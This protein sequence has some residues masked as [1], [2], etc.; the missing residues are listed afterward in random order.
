MADAGIKKVI[1][2]KENLPAFLGETQQYI[3]R[4]R[5]VSEDKNRISHW[6]TAYKLDKPDIDVIPYSFSAD[7]VAGT[8]TAIWTP[9]LDVPSFDVYVNF[10]D[11]GNWSF[12]STVSTNIYALLIPELSTAVQI[13]VQVPT[14][15]K[16]RFAGATL[17]ESNSI[18]L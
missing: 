15:P 11:S 13:A 7:S 10:N 1:I 5:I 2:L 18:A 4:Y 16:E 3:V 6:S 8:A 9:P 14:F 12:V 17:F